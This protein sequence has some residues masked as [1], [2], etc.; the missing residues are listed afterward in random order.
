M[1]L[2]IGNNVIGYEGAEAIAKAIKGNMVLKLLDLSNT[3]FID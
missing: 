2:R 1:K 3:L